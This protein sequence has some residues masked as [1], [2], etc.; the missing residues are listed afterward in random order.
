[1]P[2][3]TGRQKAAKGGNEIAALC[4]NGARKLAAFCCLMT[5]AV[6]AICRRCGVN[7]SHFNFHLLST[8]VFRH[9]S[10]LSSDD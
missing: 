10:I 7:S 8:T 6:A 2:S 4:R 1:V 9:R 3:E 5:P